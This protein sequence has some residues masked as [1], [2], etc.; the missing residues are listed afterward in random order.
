[1]IRNIL[2]CLENSVRN[3]PDK[4][5]LA[6]EKRSVTFK[7]TEEIAKRIGSFLSK[8][9]DVRNKPIAVWIG[10]DVES[11]LMFLGV[12]Y[13]GNF[14]VP[15]NRSL[16]VERVRIMLNILQP[17]A[18]LGMAED[19]K[20][21]EGGEFPFYEFDDMCNIDQNLE[22]LHLIRQEAVDTDPLYAIFTSGSTGMPKTIIAG[23][24]S[25]I[26]KLEAYRDAFDVNGNSICANQASF[27][28]DMS[29]KDVYSGLLNGCSVYIIPKELFS[30]PVKV[31]EYLNEKKVTHCFWAVTSLCLLANLRAMKNTQP[32]YLQH[33]IFSGE[34][35][36]IKV[37][38]YWL[39]NLPN[40]CF[41]NAYGPS[42]IT[43]NCT[44][45][46]VQRKY[47]LDEVVPIGKPFHNTGILVLNEHDEL[48]RENQVGEL[49]V[50]GSCL[51]FGY[52][53]NPQKTAE[54]FVQN[55]LNKSYPEKLYRTGDLVKYDKEGQLVFC[56]RKDFQ[57]KHM[58]YRIEL[59][60]IE[61]ATNALDMVERTCCIYDKERKRIVLCYE[62]PEK[63]DKELRNALKTKLPKY[64]IPGQYVQISRFPENVH[65]KIDRKRLEE[66]YLEKVRE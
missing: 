10:R 12:V 48:V 46:K 47:E 29:I 6:D 55:P 66:G 44:Y 33:V 21:V 37:L 59:G 1:M 38:N 5:Y 60:D 52:Y 23:H 51:T 8:R 65:G 42:E 7:E 18:V 17:E 28:F 57:I 41:Y 14:Y 45:F 35:I 16:P 64:M 2:E 30:F 34:T 36:P 43:G 24:R 56:G 54:V 4:V 20:Y 3:Y 53:N 19:Y 63:I 32:R 61:T 50:R 39:E 9:H 62:A 31:I 11:I 40:T 58:G 15:L 13:S 22:K 27:D 26:D 49:C 25:V